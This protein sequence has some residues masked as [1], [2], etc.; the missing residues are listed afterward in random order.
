MLVEFESVWFI[1]SV[2]RL[3]SG[4]IGR[5][6]GLGWE[7]RGRLWDGIAACSPTFAVSLIVESQRLVLL[8][9]L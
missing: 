3:V 6:Y 4:G 1:G 7:D 5:G 2:E 8:F 9:T